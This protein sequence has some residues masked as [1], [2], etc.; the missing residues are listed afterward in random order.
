[1]LSAIGFMVGAYIITRM[2][3]LLVGPRSKEEAAPVQ[4]L[5]FLT[6]CITGFVMLYLWFGPAPTLPSR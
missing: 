3:R 4:V 6:M 2:L 1:M 5:A